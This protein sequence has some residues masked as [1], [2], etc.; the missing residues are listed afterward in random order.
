MSNLDKNA[1]N[2]NKRTNDDSLEKTRMTCLSCCPL[3]TADVLGDLWLTD[4]RQA[5]DWLETKWTLEPK[6]LCVPCS[7]GP[8]PIPCLVV[9]WLKFLFWPKTIYTSFFL[10]S[11]KKI[12]GPWGNKCFL[13]LFFYSWHW[14]KYCAWISH[15]KKNITLYTAFSCLIRY[16]R[17]MCWESS[18]LLTSNGHKTGSRLNGRLSPSGCAPNPDQHHLM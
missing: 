12:S 7:L 6:R 10:P 11:M 3:L 17:R 15:Q 18:D 1:L 2:A 8:N 13:L 14:Y 9:F 16:Q 5:Q 4:K